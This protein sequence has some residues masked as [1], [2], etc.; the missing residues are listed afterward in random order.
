MFLLRPSR[1]E[2]VGVFTTARHAKD[3]ELQL[4]RPGDYRYVRRPAR[5]ELWLHRRFCVWDGVGYH[6]PRYWN[7]M[8]LCWYL[9]DSARPN[10]RVEGTRFFALRAIRAGEE[11]TI[12]YDHL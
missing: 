7:R 1:I 2:G 5:R 3:E 9:N 8:S 12:D 4:L 11:L 10:V 6:C